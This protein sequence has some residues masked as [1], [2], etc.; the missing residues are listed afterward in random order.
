MKRIVLVTET[1]EKVQYQIPESVASWQEFISGVRHRMNLGQTALIE[2]LV[3]GGKAVVRNVDAFDEGEEIFVREVIGALDIDSSKAVPSLP[4]SVGLQQTPWGIPAQFVGKKRYAQQQAEEAELSVPGRG[5][6]LRADPDIEKGTQDATNHHSVKLGGKPGC[7]KSVVGATVLRK[8][9][10][11]RRCQEPGC[12]TSAQGGRDRCIAHGGG[13]RC[14]EPGCDNSAQGAS[15]RCKAHGRG[16]R[17]QEPGCDKIA[18]GATDRCKAHGGGW[19][20]QEPGCDKG[21]LSASGR[22]VAHGGG[23]RF[24]EPGCGKG[25]QGASGRCWAHGGGKRCQELG[26]DKRAIGATNLCWAHGGVCKR[27]Q[28]LGFEKSSAG[29]A[30]R[31]KAHGGG[32]KKLCQEPG[33]DKGAQGAT[34]RCIAHGGGKRCQE[35][36]C[37]KGAAKGATDRCMAHG[38]GKPCQE[39]GC[40][41]MALG[42]GTGRCSAHGGGRRC[43]ES[44]CSKWALGPKCRCA[45]RRQAIP[46]AGVQ[47]RRSEGRDGSLHRAWRGQALSGAR[48]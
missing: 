36:G 30:N 21:A 25:A 3:E 5:E 11:G 17:C 6:K 18:Q 12:D 8:A 42:G 41:K 13:N 4:E 45:R 44:S 39:P 29:A 40:A 32:T 9:H 26:C 10:G 14:Q 27:C 37:N 23:K 48:M 22:C 35:P 34:G 16:R 15:G 2:C 19:R 31:C 33:C 46:G 7:V 43:Q 20:C 38:G 24:Q 1:G 28:D 47:Q